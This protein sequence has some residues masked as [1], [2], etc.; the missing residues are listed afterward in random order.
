MKQGT[1]NNLLLVFF[2]TLTPHSSLHV[3][4]FESLVPLVETILLT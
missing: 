1:I 4:L 3:P 2:F